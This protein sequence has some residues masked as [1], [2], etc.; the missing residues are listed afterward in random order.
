MTTPITAPVP[1]P[2]DDRPARPPAA[3]RARPRL[4]PSTVAVACLA[5]ALSIAGAAG[6]ARAQVGLSQWQPPALAQ[7]VT[8]VYP[9]DAVSRPTRFGPITVDVAVD[10]APSSGRR[11]LVLMSHGTGGSPLPDHA[12]AARLARAGFV[13]AQL[14]HEGDNHL[15]TRL[16]GPESFSLRPTEAVRVI[17]ALAADP[18]WAARLDLGR[19]G[20]HGMSAGGVTALSLAGAQWRTLDLVRH[21]LAHP[22]EDEAFC[23]QGAKSPELRAERQARF[24]RAR[25]WPE[26]V[27]PAQLKAW[28]GGRSPT[29]ERPD[30]R[31]DPRVASVTAAV[32]VAA[33]FSAD[34]LRR[35]RVP[36]GLVSARE[37][38]VLLPRFHSARVLEHCTSCE[39]LADLPGGHFDVLWPWPEAL[40]RAVAA[41][42]LRGGETTPGFDPALRDDAHARIVAF[43]RRH[44]G[45]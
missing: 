1:R 8:L 29:G 20:V 10:A 32:P 35:I 15:D 36:V 9:T 19:V 11:R 4:Q 38:T 17:D 28:H 31:P 24:D 13:V 43:H 44:L 45:Q 30:P 34:S 21:C 2:T 16:A 12:L 25:F 40:A 41:Q 3:I 39:S 5:A 23:F 27:L 14:L 37:D 42:Q 22:Q 7:P 26:F 18:A 6:D 33:I